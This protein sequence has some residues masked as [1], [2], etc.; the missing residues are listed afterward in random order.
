MGL[1]GVA[2]RGQLF[3]RQG[4]PAV[5]LVCPFLNFLGVTWRWR[6]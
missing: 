6:Q 4:E 2:L 1:E 5:D 3:E